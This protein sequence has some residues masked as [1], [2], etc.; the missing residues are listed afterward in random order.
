M[1]L[2]TGDRIEDEDSGIT[3]E[4]PHTTEGAFGKGNTHL[5]ITILDRHYSLFVGQ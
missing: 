5:G 4:E 2:T 1:Q 3:G